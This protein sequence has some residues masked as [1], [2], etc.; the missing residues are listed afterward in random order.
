MSNIVQA[1]NLLFFKAEKYHYG[2]AHTF[3]TSNCPRPHFCMGLILRGHGTFTDCSEQID[4]KV[5]PGDIIFV[6]IASTYISR[7]RGSPDVCYIS[8]HFIF[9]RNSIFT[10]QK[11]FLLQKISPQDFVHAKA[12]FEYVYNRFESD[13]E[14]E[15]LGVL[16]NFFSIL[17][18]ILPKLQR[19]KYHSID[20][21][22]RKA[23]EFIEQNY[24]QNITI[25]MLAAESQMSVS[26]FFPCFKAELGL[27]PVDYINHQR[28]SHAIVLLMD[29]NNSIESISE[30][31]GFE[32]AAYFRRVFKKITG[33]SPREYRKTSMEL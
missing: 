24:T 16:N 9:E 18:Q 31:V 14:V 20:Q 10:K 28:I 33:K 3:D 6:P 11:N 26:R 12:A 32:S 2:A 30:Q 27:T 7:W 1:S 29:H 8:M 23:T 5:G 25:E 4:I 17:Q 19:R 15:Q 22:I 13:N 21:R